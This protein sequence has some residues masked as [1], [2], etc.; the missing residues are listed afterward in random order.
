ML[1][2]STLKQKRIQIPILY[3]NYPNAIFLYFILDSSTTGTGR[4]N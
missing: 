4:R 3:P 2:S 1:Q